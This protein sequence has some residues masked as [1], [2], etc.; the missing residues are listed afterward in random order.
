MKATGY[1][2][3]AITLLA[4]VYYL[5]QLGTP[6]GKLELPYVKEPLTETSLQ[7]ALISIEMAPVT[8]LRLQSSDRMPFLRFVQTLC[9]SA[10]IPKRNNFYLSKNATVWAVIREN[11]PA[12]KKWFEDPA[13]VPNGNDV[14]IKAIAPL[15]F[16]LYP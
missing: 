14:S 12:S 16:T 10:Q 8:S 15:I 7:A 4:S 6:I 2:L 5:S 3:A 11:W 13:I 1:I 9:A